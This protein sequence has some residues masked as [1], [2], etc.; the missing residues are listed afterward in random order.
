MQR[1]SHALTAA[2]RWRRHLH[3]RYT[4]VLEVGDIAAPQEAATRRLMAVWRRGAPGGGSVAAW[5]C[6]DTAAR[7]C[8]ALWL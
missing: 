8:V 5:Q 4:D 6:G 3:S 2:A 7:R 1:R